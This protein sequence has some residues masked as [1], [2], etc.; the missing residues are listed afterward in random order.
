MVMEV[1]FVHS[2]SLSIND[3]SFFNF[4]NHFH[5]Y[6]KLLILFEVIHR[7]VFG[8]VYGQV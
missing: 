1:I 4:G 8:R 5:K 2:L 6:L 7:I 3:I